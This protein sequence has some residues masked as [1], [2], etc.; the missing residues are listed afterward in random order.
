MVLE[1]LEIFKNNYFEF[2]VY[3]FLLGNEL[4]TGQSIIQNR[5]NFRKVVFAC[6]FGTILCAFYTFLS[7][8]A[9]IRTL[10]RED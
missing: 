2:R 8:C 1:E 4:L 7:V 9:K 6:K 3:N 5:I 10:R